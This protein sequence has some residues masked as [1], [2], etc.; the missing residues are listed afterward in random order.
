MVS[1]VGLTARSD[2][3]YMA[4]DPA[5]LFLGGQVLLAPLVVLVPAG[6]CHVVDARAPLGRIAMGGF[7]A[8]PLTAALAA[9]AP[10]PERLVSITPFAALLAVYG[11]RQLA[12]WT[13]RL[14]GRLTSAP[15]SPPPVHR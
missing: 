14:T 1:W 13:G 7:F 8:A 9:Q 5:V 10:T 12:E 6:L 15:E 2:V 3:Y 11:A 4:L